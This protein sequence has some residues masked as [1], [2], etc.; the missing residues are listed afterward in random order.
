MAARRIPALALPVDPGRG[1]CVPA[2]M[3]T[4]RRC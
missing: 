3:S 4:A 1:V 2:A